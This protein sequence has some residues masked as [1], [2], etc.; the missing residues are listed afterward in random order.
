MK[1][2][3]LI[4]AIRFIGIYIA[5]I[6]GVWRALQ[7]ILRLPNKAGPKTI[8]PLVQIILTFTCCAS[9]IVFTSEEYPVS[10]QFVAFLLYAIPILIITDRY[11]C[12]I[13]PFAP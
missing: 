3:P 5:G 7:D 8:R 4:L 10:V 11:D 13:D 12:K 1:S 6:V 9:C 2:Q